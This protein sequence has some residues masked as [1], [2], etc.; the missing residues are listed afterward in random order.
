MPRLLLGSAARGLRYRGAKPLLSVS[1]LA[2]VTHLWRRGGEIVV[3]AVLN[4]RPI[5]LNGF[6]V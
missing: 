2:P 1:S 5:D 4:D 3:E 6:Y